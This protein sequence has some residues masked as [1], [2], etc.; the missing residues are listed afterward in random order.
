MSQRKIAREKIK[1]YKL[2][3]EFDYAV[4]EEKD[5]PHIVLWPLIKKVPEMADL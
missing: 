3:F 5:S 4:L 2:W 1:E